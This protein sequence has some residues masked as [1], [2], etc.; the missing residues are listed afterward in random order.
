LQS[1]EQS[2]GFKEKPPK[3]KSFFR[4]GI[5]GDWKNVLTSKQIDTIIHDHG[6]VMETHRYI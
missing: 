4:K 5:V 6:E 1:L 2:D 3:V